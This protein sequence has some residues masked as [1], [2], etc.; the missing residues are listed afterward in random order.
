MLYTAD[1]HEYTLVR[2]NNLQTIRAFPDPSFPF[3]ITRLQMS[4]ISIPYIPWH[5]HDDLE[6]IWVESGTLIV[7]TTEGSIYIH[8]N[9]GLFINTRILHTMQTCGGK[10]CIFFSI[11]FLSRLLFPQS[12]ATITTQYLNPILFSKT[13]RYVHLLKTESIL[14][15]IL[16]HIQDITEVYYNPP[17]CSELFILNKL[18]DIWRI[19]L[20]YAESAYPAPELTKPVINDYSRAV[21]ALHYIAEHYAEPIT[22]DDIAA[23]IHISKSECCRCFKRSIST[24]PVEFLIQYRIMESIRKMQTKDAEANSISDLATSVG[25]NSTSYF[26]KQFKRY[27]NCTPLEYKKKLLSGSNDIEPAKELLQNIT[28]SMDL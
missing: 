21:E 11:R 28:T 7:G 18:Y 5:W 24:S 15:Q 4:Q 17:A 10:D 3:I 23:A 22:L 20:I 27:L 1:P 12:N 19:L 16:Q 25:F 8:A 13:L 2:T 9:E 26:N 6:F 14:E